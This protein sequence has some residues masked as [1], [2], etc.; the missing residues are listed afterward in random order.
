M[1]LARI[2]IDRLRKWEYSSTH[3]RWEWHLIKREDSIIP[4]FYRYAVLFVE[5]RYKRQFRIDYVCT[6]QELTRFC[7]DQV[8][9]ANK[10]TP[11]K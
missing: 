7:D 8:K 5:N 2:N 9:A 3:Y 11:L 6:E 1:I 10:I 4:N